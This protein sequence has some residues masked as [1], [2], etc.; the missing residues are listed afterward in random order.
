MNSTR[1]II[2]IAGIILYFIAPVFPNAF[3][4]ST[5]YSAEMNG[6]AG[7][8]M[9]HCAG[10]MSIAVNPAG[11]AGIGTGYRFNDSWELNI[12][13]NFL[14]NTGTVPFKYFFYSAMPGYYRSLGYFLSLELIFNI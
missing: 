5:D 7:A 11:M 14:Y 1:N 3:D 10:G 8:G 9:A 4:I 12:S 2:V 6:M 13:G